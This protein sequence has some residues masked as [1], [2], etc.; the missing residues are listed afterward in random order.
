M[1][2]IVYACVCM[3]IQECAIK[4]AQAEECNGLTDDRVSSHV[5]VDDSGI[6]AKINEQ[7]RNVSAGMPLAGCIS[8]FDVCFVN[9]TGI[10][11][12]TYKYIHI[13][14]YTCTYMHS[15]LEIIAKVGS[16]ALH[17]WAGDGRHEQAS[18]SRSVTIH[19]GSGWATVPW[20]RAR[21]RA[22]SLSAPVRPGFKLGRRWTRVN[23][24]GSHVS[25]RPGHWAIGIMG[26]GRWIRWDSSS[27]S[28]KSQPV[29]T[30]GR[31]MHGTDGAG[32]DAISARRIQVHTMMPAAGNSVPCGPGCRRPI[33]NVFYFRNRRFSIFAQVPVVQVLPR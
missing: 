12:N 2:N 8:Y 17:V 9:D 26:P 29:T 21:G 23:Q 28:L 1:Y 16:Q 18:Q 20:G 25:P 33:T 24:S 30:L 22:A 3:Y 14:T 19:S 27:S 7:E 4:D 11:A 32:Y 31:A 5:L 13:H 10:L 6:A 15:N